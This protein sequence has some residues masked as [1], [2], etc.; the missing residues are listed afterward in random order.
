MYAIAYG[1]QKPNITGIDAVSALLREDCFFNAGKGG[2]MILLVYGDRYLYDMHIKKEAAGL[3]TPEVNAVYAEEWDDSL[4]MQCISAPFLEEKK[5]V[6][7]QLQNP[8]A[9]IKQKSL[10]DYIQNPSAHTDLYLCMRHPDKR[11]E[12]YKTLSKKGCIMEFPKASEG[13]VYRSVKKRL[14]RKYAFSPGEVDRH[15]D[16]L[17][18]RLRGYQYEEDYDLYRVMKYTDMIGNAGQIDRETVEYFIPETFTQKAYELLK[19]MLSGMKTEMMQLASRLIRENDENRIG[20]LSL[21]LSQVRTCY[22][23]VLFPEMLHREILRTLGINS[24]QLN[25][26]YS[27]YSPAQ[28][29]KAY[30][31]LQ[32]GVNSLKSGSDADSAFM[33]AL[34]NAATALYSHEEKRDRK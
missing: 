3:E 14:V 6:V 33:M 16:I 27:M 15:R 18:Q 24:Y 32:G 4:Y 19:L 2:K 34:I 9:C 25:G 1:G 26:S 11:S 13:D 10:T 12:V 30:A 29:A 20:L 5:I 28:Y 17:M 22:K 31:C 7:V 21:V 8:G 23:A